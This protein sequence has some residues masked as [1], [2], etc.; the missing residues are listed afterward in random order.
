M[1]LFT[2]KR[3]TVRAQTKYNVHSLP[4]YTIKAY[5]RRRNLYVPGFTIPSESTKQTYIGENVHPSLYRHFLALFFSL[6]CSLPDQGDPRKAS[7]YPQH[8][9]GG[10]Y[11]HYVHSCL[12][13]ARILQPSFD[14]IPTHAPGVARDPPQSDRAPPQSVTL[15]QTIEAHSRPCLPSE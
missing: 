9:W 4:S 14:L 2:A 13:Y 1:P 12:I 6:T 3:P 5:C 11:Q 7:L 15:P 8:L 10:L